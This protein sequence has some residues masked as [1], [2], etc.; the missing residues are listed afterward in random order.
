MGKSLA[1]GAVS[2]AHRPGWRNSC[3]ILRHLCRC[4]PQLLYGIWTAVRLLL[5]AD[6][7]ERTLFYGYVRYVPCRV[8][9]MRTG[10][11]RGQFGNLDIPRRLFHYDDAFPWA[12]AVQSP[13]RSLKIFL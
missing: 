6:Y 10:L 3:R 9:Q 4:V 13:E 8:G 1:I 2:F 7:F 12:F 11:G 5:H